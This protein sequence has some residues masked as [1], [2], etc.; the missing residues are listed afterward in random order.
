MTII[1]KCGAVF[2]HAPKT[3][4]S[5]VE[6]VLDEL[7]LISKR[8]GHPH[9]IYEMGLY[10]HNFQSRRQ[11]LKN[12]F[13]EKIFG[14]RSLNDKP[15]IFT[16]VRNPIRWYESWWRYMEGIGWPNFGELGSVSRWHPNAVLEDLVDNDFNTFMLR[17]NKHRPGYATE[18][19]YSY[20]RPGISFVGRTENLAEDLSRVLHYLKVDFDETILKGM[21]KV[22]ESKGSEVTWEPDVLRTTELLELPALCHFGYWDPSRVSETIGVKTGICPALELPTDAY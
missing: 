8:I 21:E 19:L 22:N 16:M 5:W 12:Y 20:A 4:G 11:I 18:L 15:F 7:G 17:V 14:K 1:L 9:S 2:V 3:G 6:T 13:F 10:Y